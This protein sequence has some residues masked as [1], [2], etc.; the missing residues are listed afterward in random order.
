MMLVSMCEILVIVA[1]CRFASTSFL[2]LDNTGRFGARGFDA[3]TLV[4]VWAQDN[5]DMLEV[6]SSQVVAFG[7]DAGGW[8]SCRLACDTEHQSL[9]SGVV[10]Q[11]GFCDDAQGTQCQSQSNW[12]YQSLQHACIGKDIV[13][14]LHFQLV[15]ASGLSNL[16]GDVKNT[17]A[18]EHKDD[19]Q[20][21][22]YC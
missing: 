2:T 12:I 20:A 3:Q 21:A 8:A 5:V 6:W 4:A 10:T 18:F 9:A 13:V 11:F 7:H 16:R 17:C 19:Y 14:L 15:D 1:Q 22:P